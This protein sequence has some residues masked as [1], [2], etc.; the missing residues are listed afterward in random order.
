MWLCVL[1]HNSGDKQENCHPERWQPTTNNK[2]GDHKSSPG[3]F[4]GCGRNTGNEVSL[5][6][7]HENSLSVSTWCH[8]SLSQN[9]FRNT[10]CRVTEEK[11]SKWAA[12][13]VQFTRGVRPIRRSQFTLTFHLHERPAPFML[14]LWS[15][16]RWAEI[17]PELRPGPRWSAPIRPGTRRSSS[18]S[19]PVRLSSL[20]WSWCVFCSGCVHD[21]THVSVHMQQRFSPVLVQFWCCSLSLSLLDRLI[22][23]I[24]L[25]F[26][27]WIKMK[28]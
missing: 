1:L 14:T 10:F 15:P 3:H 26:I 16:L 17:L 28:D 21:V 20:W 22:L 11:V 25:T 9:V 2:P 24:S 12:M 27:C 8:I 23:Y 5:W 6:E 13:L 18:E 19:E 7:W 4:L